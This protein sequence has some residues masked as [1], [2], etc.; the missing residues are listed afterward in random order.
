MSIS[1][2][3]IFTLMGFSVAAIGAATSV[4]VLK[5]A[6]PGQRVGAAVAA[7][8]ILITWTVTGAAIWL[9][10]PKLFEWTLSSYLVAS[11]T[12]A[13]A[14]GF[15]VHHAMRVAVRKLAGVPKNQSL[16]QTLV[17]AFS[18]EQRQIIATHEAGHLIVHAAVHT[19]LLKNLEARITTGISGTAGYVRSL[20]STLHQTFPTSRNIEWECHMLLAGD[21][22]TSITK[23]EYFTGAVSDMQ[24]WHLLATKLLVNGLTG[25][26]F[27]LSNDP[28]SQ[29]VRWK[30]YKRLLDT[31]RLTV[32]EFL[33]ANKIL[34]FKI[35][36]KLQSQMHL[37]NED[38]MALLKSV[39][40]VDLIPK[41]MP[42]LASHRNAQKVV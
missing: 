7:A 3:T 17:P 12:A 2:D 19:S 37:N 32:G 21:M 1:S 42:G 13:I 14:T 26:P 34:I 41:V 40:A 24:R 36:D 27:P 30:S 16:F 23:G 29:D 4:R 28:A 20:E 35:A 25:L 22:A 6:M 31:Q 5:N 18:D 9:V 33:Q 8:L 39:N 38:C 15:T 10:G 11:I